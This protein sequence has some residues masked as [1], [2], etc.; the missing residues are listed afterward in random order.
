MKRNR[1]RIIIIL[2]SSILLLLVLAGCTDVGNTDTS[3]DS[4]SDIGDSAGDHF[5][6]KIPNEVPPNYA[7][8]VRAYGLEGVKEAIENSDL[9][10]Y[11]KY[12]YGD[13]VKEIYKAMF[14]SFHEVGYFYQVKTSEKWKDSDITFSLR[15]D[16]EYHFIIFTYPLFPDVGIYS[17]IQYKG[18]LY[19]VWIMLLDKSYTEDGQTISDYIYSKRGW[20]T[21]GETIINDK[22]VYY[23]SFNHIRGGLSYI[24]SNCYYYIRP[25]SEKVAVEELNELLS[26]I[27]FEKVE[28]DNIDYADYPPEIYTVGILGF[29]DNFPVSVDY[30]AVTKMYDENAFNYP[31]YDGLA[32]IGQEQIR[33]DYVKTYSRS[34]YYYYPLREYSSYDGKDGVSFSENGSGRVLSYINHGTIENT[35]ELLNDDEYIAIAKAFVKKLW[36]RVPYWDSYKISIEKDK[37]IKGYYSISFEKYIHGIKTDENIYVQVA[38]SGEIRMFSADMYDRISP[39]VDL[40]KFEPKPIKAAVCKKLDDIYSGLGK[41]T[42]DKYKIRYFLSEPILSVL[43]DGTTCYVYDVKVRFT[44]VED[45]TRYTDIVQVAVSLDW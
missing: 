37:E 6:D 27:E 9:R 34:P 22:T 32:I 20:E 35:E 23:T 5:N 21:N 41:E 39:Y 1:I 25:G 30:G 16:N 7:P 24:D 15:G 43:A 36:G 4:T 13:K 3:G 8:G 14:E 10:E 38:Y 28:I 19:H 26:L 45:A 11:E 18:N 31:P 17:Y 12:V 33:G 29:S 2:L 40:S 42:R 44:S